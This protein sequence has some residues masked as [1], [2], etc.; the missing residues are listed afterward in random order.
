MGIKLIL[1]TIMLS[2]VLKTMLIPIV[3]SRKL[4]SVLQSS[5][6]PSSKGIHPNKTALAL[7]VLPASLPLLALFLEKTLAGN[8]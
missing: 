8:G 3:L 1:L 5:A 4:T 2:T 6:V 7:L